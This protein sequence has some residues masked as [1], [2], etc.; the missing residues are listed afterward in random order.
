MARKTYEDSEKERLDNAYPLR[1]SSPQKRS[2]AEYEKK[3]NDLLKKYGLERK[4]SALEKDIAEYK[5]KLSPEV[6]D[7]LEGKDTSP[8]TVKTD[9]KTGAAVA[10]VNEDKVKAQENSKILAQNA[11]KNTEKVAK[12]AP[13]NTKKSAK[14]AKKSAVSVK[15]QGSQSVGE[16]PKDLKVSSW[17]TFLTFRAYRRN[18]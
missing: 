7:R 18:L 16:K 11:P 6:R 5:S 8:I 4:Q 15:K 3:Y 9:S 17:S 14:V 13:K 10:E 2:D 1:S 12:V